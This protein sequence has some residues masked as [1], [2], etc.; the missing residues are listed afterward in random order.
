MAEKKECPL[1]T[2]PMRLVQREQVDRLPGA[3]RTSARKTQ[4]WVCPDC[5]YFEEA[6]EG[7]ERV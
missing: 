6:D 3:A 5:D 4:E 2:E 1:C 7:N